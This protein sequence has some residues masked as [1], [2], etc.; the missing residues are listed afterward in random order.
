MAMLLQSLVPY[1]D[2]SILPRCGV[3]NGTISVLDGFESKLI[4]GKIKVKR[5]T[6]IFY[7]I[8]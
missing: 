6:D 8:S 5:S 3:V 2:L 1:K 4:S 7:K